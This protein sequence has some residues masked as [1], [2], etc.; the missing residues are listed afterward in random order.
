MHYTHQRTFGL[1]KYNLY[2]SYVFRH[3]LC[4]YQLVPFLLFGLASHG[5]SQHLYHSHE[6]RISH[7]L[8]HT[9]KKKLSAIHNQHNRKADTHRKTL[10]TFA[11][12]SPLIRKVTNLFKRTNL[13]IAFRPTNTIYHQ[14]QNTTGNVNLNTSGIYRL[15]CGSCTKSY[16]GQSGRSI[17]VR[18]R[19]HTRYI[20]TN[21]PISA[22]VLHILNNRHEYGPQEQPLHLLHT[23]SKGN[24]KNHWDTFYI[25][26]LHQLNLLID[27]QQP[28]EH[29]PLYA[30]GSISHQTTTHHDISL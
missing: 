5:K 23:Y 3:R 11:Y 22:Y 25:Q 7:E 12:F 16:T 30:L 8:I 27:E 29:N 4:C 17:S 9:I 18:Y 21:N 1:C 2:R 24:F 15:Q 19:E 10:I 6:Q 26:Q 13:N 28:Q 14:L 20:R